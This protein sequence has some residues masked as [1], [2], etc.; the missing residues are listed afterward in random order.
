MAGLIC[1][2]CGQLKHVGVAHACDE[3]DQVELVRRLNRAQRA[4][5]SAS[6]PFMAEALFGGLAEAMRRAAEEIRANI[7]L[8]APRAPEWAQHVP[9]S[10]TVI[11]E[12]PRDT[13]PIRVQAYVGYPLAEIESRR[14]ETIE[15][16]LA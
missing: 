9:T 14:G 13:D 6:A 15:G 3:P 10:Y 5:K 8:Q 1:A 2:D 12:P 7:K 11:P 16:E 4:T